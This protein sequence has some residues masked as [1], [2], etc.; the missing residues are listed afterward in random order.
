MFEKEIFTERLKKQCQDFNLEC[1]GAWQIGPS[2]YVAK[3]KVAN[4]DGWVFAIYFDNTKMKFRDPRQMDRILQL[5]ILEGFEA[6]ALSED[7]DDPVTFFHL[8]AGTLG[9][10]PI[11][12]PENALNYA[13][14]FL[15]QENDSE[16][17]WLDYPEPVEL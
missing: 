16:I 7:E 11:G 14:Q 8:T 17:P 5:L 13:T 2:V 15:L 9:E 12:N 10:C 3:V 1:D 4:D 6:G